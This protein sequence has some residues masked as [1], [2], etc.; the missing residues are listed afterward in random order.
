MTDFLVVKTSYLI[1]SKSTTNQ[2][3]AKKPSNCHI[4]SIEFS[5]KSADK[6]S[7]KS[8]SFIYMT[9]KT[10]MVAQSTV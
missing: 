3:K 2:R 10:L 9:H 8:Y 1:A 7:L 5:S 4:P 6:H